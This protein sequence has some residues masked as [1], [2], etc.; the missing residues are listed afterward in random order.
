M[1][2]SARIQGLGTVRA[3]EHGIGVIKRP[4]LRMS[5][6]DA[7]IKLMLAIK[8]LLDPAGILNNGRVLREGEG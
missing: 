8:S 3:P 7:E 2:F 1:S 4:F 6:S 5:R